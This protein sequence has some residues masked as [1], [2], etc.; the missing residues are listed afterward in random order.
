M[1]VRRVQAGLLLVRR[2][3]LGTRAALHGAGAEVAALLFG[4]TAQEA[5]VLG[6]AAARFAEAEMAQSSPWPG[7]ANT[8]TL[9]LVSTVDLSLQTLTLSGLTGSATPDNASLPIYDETGAAATTGVWRQA[10][11]SLTWT[12]PPALALLPGTLRVLTFALFNSLVGQPAPAVFIS[13]GPAIAPQL[14]RV[15]DEAPAV[16]LCTLASGLT[17]NAT[18]VELAVGAGLLALG[19]YLRIDEEVLLAVALRAESSVAVA[20]AQRGTVPDQHANGSV[21]WLLLPGAAAADAAPL[22]IHQPGFVTRAVGQSS[23]Y[24]CCSGANCSSLNTIS[25]TLVSNLDLPG[26]TVVSLAGLRGTQTADTGGATRVDQAG[27]NVSRS[28]GSFAVT[29]AALAGIEAGGFVRCGGEVIAV[30]D[31][32]P[33]LLPAAAAYL[34]VLQPAA[35]GVA[36]GR[37][38]RCDGEEML[39]LQGDALS[40]L[41]FAVQRGVGGTAAA[42]HADGATVTVVEMTVLRGAAGVNDSWIVVN[43]TAGW[44]LAVPSYIAVD[45][46]V[47][48]VTAVVL[49]SNTLNV[50][51][52]AA[53]SAAQAHA[54]GAAVTA[55][56]GALS[57]SGLSE[58]GTV[59]ALSSRNLFPI[60]PGAYLDLEREVLLVVSVAFTSADNL[61]CSLV[62]ERG[63]AGTRPEP[64]PAGTV[65]VIRRSA[66]LLSPIP[67]A[68]AP[69]VLNITAPALAGIRPGSLLRIDDEVVLVTAVNGTAVTAARAVAGTRPSAHA[70]AATASPHRR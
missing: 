43:S 67:N 25:V 38:V 68:S 12:L 16:P 35:A 41:K 70:A 5:G 37:F 31:V 7:A 26:G 65:A 69:A 2:A 4:P 27:R 30:L 15:P 10:A 58:S 62:V 53:G 61:S 57:T 39:V 34:A 3:Q 48:L 50:V 13:A 28:D 17:P 46:E 42:D 24:P 36:P 44:R 55:V 64:H 21:V 66:V 40:P 20:R 33:S 45:A 1:L 19:N 32:R 54:D 23:S 47:M 9:T 18:I 56:D 63:Q 49:S 14:V 52:A 11:G 29:S 51:R 60:A 59:L 22:Q 6:V 8:L